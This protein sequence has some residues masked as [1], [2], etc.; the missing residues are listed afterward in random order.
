MILYLSDVLKV[1]IT[2]CVSADAEE[3]ASWAIKLWGC[4]VN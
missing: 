4:H 2:G 3:R 1:R